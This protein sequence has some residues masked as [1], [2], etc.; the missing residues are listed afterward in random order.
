MFGLCSDFNTVLD[1]ESYKCSHGWRLPLQVMVCG[2]LSYECQGVSGCS[3]FSFWVREI[4]KPSIDKG[5]NDIA[6]SLVSEVIYPCWM[7]QSSPLK[8]VGTGRWS[9]FTQLRSDFLNPLGIGF[10]PSLRVP[11]WLE[12]EYVEG[13][14]KLPALGD[15]SR[16]E[17]WGIAGLACLYPAHLMVWWKGRE[18]KAVEP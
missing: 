6:L 4:E 3:W 2:G 1:L 10:Y 18:K 11:G 5:R 13:A 8:A 15:Q 9:G 14:L 12:G 7:E 17:L 16:L